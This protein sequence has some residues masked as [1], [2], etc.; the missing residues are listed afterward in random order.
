MRAARF[1]DLKD[2]RNALPFNL[3]SR[4]DE[5]IFS[6]YGLKV[7]VFVYLATMNGRSEKHDLSFFIR[8]WVASRLLEPN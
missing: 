6:C 3:H 7:C 5:L 1:P 4:R 8:R 2:G